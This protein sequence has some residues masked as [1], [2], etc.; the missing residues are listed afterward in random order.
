MIG[1]AH[2]H[3]GLSLLAERAIWRERS[4]TLWVADVHLGK[5]ATFRALGQPVPAGTTIENLNRLSALVDFYGASRLVFLGD[6]FHARQSHAAAARALLA[7]RDRHKD[8]ELVLV[9]GNHDHRAGDPAPEL[10]IKVVTEP[11]SSDA[12]E[13]RHH[14]LQDEDAL[15]A[16]GATVLA[17][18]LHPVVRVRGAGHDSVRVQCFLLQGRQI[19]LPAFGEF[20]GG[21]RPDRAANVCAITDAGLIYIEGDRRA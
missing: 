5:A 20:T 2:E 12:I 10:R 17:G 19:V 8:L 7:W 13:A 18:H 3:R 16:D 11:Y 1:R 9:R 14:P 6:L 21:G 4:R 15:C